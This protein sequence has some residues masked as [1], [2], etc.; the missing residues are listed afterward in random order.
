L[1]LKRLARDPG[2]LRWALGVAWSR[3]F[4]MTMT[5]GAKIQDAHMLIPYAG[6]PQL[7]I[8]VLTICCLVGDACYRV[9][10]VMSLTGAV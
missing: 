9:Y 10:G 1:K 7:Y 4:T 5:I 3:S 2:R 6:N 8:L